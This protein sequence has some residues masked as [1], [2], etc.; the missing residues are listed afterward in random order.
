[1]WQLL[2]NPLPS[3][4]PVYEECTVM[5]FT[6]YHHT[7]HFDEVIS[8]PVSGSFGFESQPGKQLF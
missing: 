6:T 7:K 2:E 4:H 3:I 5:I 1:M 8:T